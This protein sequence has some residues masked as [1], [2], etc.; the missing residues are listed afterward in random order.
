M[1]TPDK[2]NGCL[3]SFVDSFLCLDFLTAKRQI[4]S[5]LFAPTGFF[6]LILLLWGFLGNSLAHSLPLSHASSL[7]RPHSGNSSLLALVW[8]GAWRKRWERVCVGK[9]PHAKENPLF[10]SSFLSYGAF[11]I[12]SILPLGHSQAKNPI[13][14]LIF[15]AYMAQWKGK[16]A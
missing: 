4:K 14:N 9:A 1:L 8:P 3:R 5:G 2:I 6:I 10:F 13:K 15:F 12:P 11:P 16:R 7:P